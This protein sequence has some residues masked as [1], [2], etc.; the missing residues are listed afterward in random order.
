MILAP[1]WGLSLRQHPQR[2]LQR[3][4]HLYV[5]QQQLHRLVYTVN[6]YPFTRLKFYVLAT[7]GV[8]HSFLANH[9]FPFSNDPWF[10]ILNWF[11]QLTICISSTN[12]VN[13]ILG[14]CHCSICSCY[15]SDDRFS[16]NWWKSEIFCHGSYTQWWTHVP[17]SMVIIVTLAWTLTDLIQ[18]KFF[19]FNWIDID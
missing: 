3:R 5:Q 9:L 7:W 13:I 1:S 16:E 17:F 10:A 4:K 19:F 11:Q 18:M 15:L 2:R 6:L 12:H 14:H 8:K